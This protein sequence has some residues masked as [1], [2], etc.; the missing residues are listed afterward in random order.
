MA[1]LTNYGNHTT[2]PEYFCPAGLTAHQKI[3]VLTFNLPLFI[4]AFLGN[5]LIIASLQKVF[6]LH[7]PSKLLL[8]CLASTD[9]CVGLIT[10]PLY[11]ALK[12]STEHSKSCHYLKLLFDTI[13]SMFCA[14]S[15]LTISA[16]SFDR[17]L[18]LLLG[19]RYRQVVTL[20][21]VW[22]VVVTFW[23][24]STAA[25]VIGSFNYH[26]GICIAC[27]GVLL[28][29]ITSTF[30]YTKIYL[31]LHHHQAQV[32]DGVRQRQPNG[33]IP[34]NIARYKK[35][36]S[37]ALWIKITL[38]V[39]YLPYGIFVSIVAITGLHMKSASLN[40][41]WAVTISLLLSNSSLNPFLYYWRIR[42]VRHAVKDTIRQFCRSSS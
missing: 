41:A 31:T 30:C 34:L 23:L 36:V 3:F 4:T 6:S 27:M 22:L 40:M 1:N 18:A 39:C 35:S 19:L 5:A 16:I 17:L 21:K 32:Q 25:A 42:E 24:I 14:V 12:M 37:S 11:V 10:Q 26:A 28:C 29:T 7:P 38:L 15:L 8:G 2:I 20:R 33:R 9:L 13:G